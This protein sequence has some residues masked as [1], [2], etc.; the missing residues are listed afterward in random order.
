MQV[1]FEDFCPE[2]FS[3]HEHPVLVIEN[4]WTVE[5]RNY[6]RQA[7]GQ[8]TWT[9]LRE[10]PRLRETF[11]NCGNWI[12][13]EMAQA[14]AQIFLDRLA[15]RCIMA[16]M[17]SF[18]NIVRRHLSFSYYSYAAGDCL[19]THDD[20][21]Q[22]NGTAALAQEAGA[23]LR[24]LAL[25]TYLHNE[26]QPDWGGELIIYH[27]IRGQHAQP[28]LM[29][30]HCIAPQPGS[31]VIFTVPRFHRVSRV[32]PTSGNNKRLSIA[33]WFMTEQER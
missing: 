24:R 18:P 30:T 32:D 28:H 10:M 13:A 23:P 2:S 29:I 33:G 21:A 11:P 7:M 1:Q 12:K 9:Q 26:W 15:L 25:V 6:F 16:Y 20:T 19:L 14:E 4:F 27:S 17:E 31:L 8:A 5:E 3:F 22:A